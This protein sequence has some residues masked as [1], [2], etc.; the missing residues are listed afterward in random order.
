MR[1]ILS[2]S[3]SLFNFVQLG[4]G[5]GGRRLDALWSL[6]PRPGLMAVSWPCPL[7]IMPEGHP[8]L[9]PIAI[10]SEVRRI[11]IEPLVHFSLKDKN[12][13]QVESHIFLYHRQGLAI[14]LSWAETIP[15]PAGR[16]RARPGL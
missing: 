1:L 9:A 12:R 2:L 6:P 3:I 15:E 16:D 13:N 5:S 10:G 8:A 7:L 4:Q 14:S 11:G